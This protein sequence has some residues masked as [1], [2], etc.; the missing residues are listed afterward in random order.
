MSKLLLWTMILLTWLAMYQRLASDEASSMPTVAG[1]LVVLY[2][3][4]AT[5]KPKVAR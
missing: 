5:V 1:A 4:Y 3:G 2:L